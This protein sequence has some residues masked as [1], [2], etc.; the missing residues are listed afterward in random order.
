V[1]TA[2]AAEWLMDTGG[3]GRIL[4]DDQVAI[5]NASTW[6][7]AVVAIVMSVVV[8]RLAVLVERW[9]AARWS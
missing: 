5:D 7:V 1:L 3:L 6:A 9:G 4:S 8:Y 2:I